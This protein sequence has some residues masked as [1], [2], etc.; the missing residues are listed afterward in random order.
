MMPARAQTQP[1][2]HGI[3]TVA[4]DPAA[5]TLTV[6]RWWRGHGVT[7][8]PLNWLPPLGSVATGPEGEP[9]AA[10]WLYLTGTPVAWIEQL[11]SNPEAPKRMRA[12]ALDAVVEDLL[13]TADRL[14]C[15]VV[16]AATASLSVIRRGR[17]HG[18]LL[19]PMERL[20]VRYQPGA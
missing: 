14:G 6:Q 9:L 16:M 17:R 2:R 13:W 12:R 19:R 15:R 11:V 4:W 1:R 10:C 7:G 18:F 8:V 3:T 5:H 20:V